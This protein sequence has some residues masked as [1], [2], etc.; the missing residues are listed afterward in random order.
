M[1]VA[2]TEESVIPFVPDQE[3]QQDVPARL[4]PPGVRHRPLGGVP[5]RPAKLCAELRRLLCRLLFGSG[6]PSRKLML[7]GKDLHFAL[8]KLSY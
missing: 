2:I 5:H 7:C 4:L 8:R 6:Q 3:A 1:L